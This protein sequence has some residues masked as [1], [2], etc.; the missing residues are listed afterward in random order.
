MRGSSNTRREVVPAPFLGVAAVLNVSVIALTFDQGSE[1]RRLAGS[2]RPPPGSPREAD[3]VL[4]D[5]P[6]PVTDAWAAD[7]VTVTVTGAE[8]TDTCPSLTVRTAV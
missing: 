2:Q 1:A 5:T 4:Q 6:L 7:G 3:R 8:L